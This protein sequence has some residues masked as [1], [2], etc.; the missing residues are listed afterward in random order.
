MWRNNLLQKNFF[1]LLPTA[2]MMFVGYT[3]CICLVNG[4][5]ACACVCALQ[6]FS[7]L[8]AIAACNCA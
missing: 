3:L 7:A 8:I 4:L 1:T 5:I 6:Q 2:Y